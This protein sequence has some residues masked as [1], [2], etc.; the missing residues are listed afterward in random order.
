MQLLANWLL[1]SRF[2]VAKL[3]AVPDQEEDQRGWHSHVFTTLA[4]ALMWAML[5]LERLY[6]QFF[7][8]LQL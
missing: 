1:A 7:A 6:D 4:G 8:W 3:T 5:C 2:L